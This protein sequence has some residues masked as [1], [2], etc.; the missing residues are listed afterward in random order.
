LPNGSWNNEPFDTAL[1]LLALGGA[2]ERARA[3]L[4]EAQY[5]PGGWPG[6]TRPAGGDSYPQHIST[7]AWVTLALM[8]PL[9]APRH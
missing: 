3:Y 4:L 6:T 8:Q 9:P 2:N 1:A 7:T 5:E